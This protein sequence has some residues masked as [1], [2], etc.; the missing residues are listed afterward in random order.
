VAELLSDKE[1]EKLIDICIIG[2]DKGCIK[3]NS[4][5]LRLG[6]KIRFKLTE[7]EFA[8]KEGEWLELGPG[9]SI[10][11][12]SY[13]KIDFSTK[14]VQRIFKDAMLFGLIN[15]R[16]TLMREGVTQVSTK[17]D[18]GFTGVLDWELRNN[19]YKSLKLEFKEKIFNLMIFKLKE[20]EIP[21]V[22]YGARPEDFYQD[23]EGLKPSARKIPAQIPD[24]LIK[25]PTREKVDHKK[26]LR[27]AGPPVSYI[28]EE[29]VQLDGEIEVVDKSVRVL[30]EK[31]EEQAK[32]VTKNLNDHFLRI[33]NIFNKKFVGIYGFFLALV[34][35]TLGVIQ[36]FRTAEVTPLTIIIPL[37][38]GVL[39]L[40][41]TVTGVISKR[42]T[43]GDL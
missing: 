29:L 32:S 34:A 40:I 16:T 1:I 43:K 24:R 13:Q 20:N 8:L 22:P 30:K 21:E 19:C 18:A 25:K 15:T 27:E 33:E 6:S 42:K 31:L 36:I 4:Y 28:G 10:D 11:I 14:T 26:Q 5:E 39:I 12:T 2:G 35:I 37:A 41:L 3:P 38:I 9:E 23:S 17:I 7:E